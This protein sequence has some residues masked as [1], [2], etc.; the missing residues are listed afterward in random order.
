MRAPEGRHSSPHCRRDPSLT[1]EA[2]REPR[3][4][5]R[6]LGGVGRISGTD[7]RHGVVLT[8]TLEVMPTF[9]DLSHDV[10]DGMVTYPGLPAPR[11]GS[12]L[13]RAASRGRYAEGVEFDIGSIEMC[14]N[15]GTYLDT[16]FHRYPDGH[17]LT[18]LDLARCADLA[19]TVVSVTHQAITAADVPADV[20][21]RAVVFHTGWDRCR[22]RLWS[23]PQA[24]IARPS[25]DTQ[26]DRVW[27]S[28]PAL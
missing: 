17:D 3:A 15:T 8:D 25:A 13:T 19:L 26:A 27:A 28:C 20:A 2:V 14:A 16:P 10:L 6:T 22:A 5:R 11:L 9:I 18:G 12:V 21:G 23:G 24:V 4:S 7:V 1:C